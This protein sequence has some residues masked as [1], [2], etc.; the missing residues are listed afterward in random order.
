MGVVGTPVKTLDSKDGARWRVLRFF[1]ANLWLTLL[2]FCSNFGLVNLFNT[3]IV[4][5]KPPNNTLDSGPGVN[6]GKPLHL[7]HS[8][9]Q[10]TSVHSTPTP[11]PKV[12]STST[13]GGA[14]I[15]FILILSSLCQVGSTDSLSYSFFFNFSRARKCKKKSEKS[16]QGQ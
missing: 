1:P 16:K 4:Q 7:P 10:S 8:H 12:L 13:L 14:F 9:P 3:Y 2:K 5:H 11:M 6:F 15:Y